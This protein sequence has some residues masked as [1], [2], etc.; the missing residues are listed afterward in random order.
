M[1]V[2]IHSLGKGVFKSF[3]HCL[4]ELFVFL[5]LSCKDF[6]YILDTLP[7]PDLQKFSS[8]LWVV[9]LFF[10]KCLLKQKIVNLRNSHLFFFCFV[11]CIFDVTCEKLLPNQGSWFHLYPKS[12]IVWALACRSLIYFELTFV[13]S[14][15]Q[16]SEF[17][18]LPV[19]VQPSQ[20][21]FLR[22]TVFLCWL[23][24]HCQSETID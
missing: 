15:K 2:Y 21:H 14:V 11:I 19:D 1:A 3:A 24:W 9:F 20:Q 12:F 6:S 16:G 22:H 17:V 4:I 10:W 5:L 13:Y 8:I 18:L 7:L 23:S